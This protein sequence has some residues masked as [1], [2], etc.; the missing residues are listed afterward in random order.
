MTL[1]SLY[2]EEVKAF[3][4]GYIAGSILW[5]YII[6]RIKGVDITK[7]G[8]GNPGM[9]N[10]YRALG[11]KWAFVVFVLDFLKAF[12]PTKFLGLWA[13]I[14]AILGHVFSPMLRFK[15]GK[16]IASSVG[17]AFAFNWKVGLL[18]VVAFAVVFYAFR[19]VSVASLTMMVVF[20]IS[21]VFFLARSYVYAFLGLLILSVFTHREN[22]KRLLR[23]EE[24]AI[25][26]GKD[27]LR[28]EKEG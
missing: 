10:V 3:L 23:G 28:S 7:V 2:V 18:G 24:L 26:F 15:G 6:P 19:Y 16:G 27:E 17:V 13:G 11:A 25:K 21:S 5:G 4:I 1:S 9:T 22:I 8:S 14:G 12:I 20:T